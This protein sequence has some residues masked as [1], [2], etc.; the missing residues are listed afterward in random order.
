M[1]LILEAYIS[2]LS[3]TIG[4]PLD[5]KSGAAAEAFRIADIARSRL[6]LEALAASGARAAAG[7]AEMADLIRREQDAQKQISALYGLLANVRAAPTDQQDP[8]AVHALRVRID[9]LRSAR[10]ALGKEIEKRFPAYARLVNPKPATVAQAQSFIRPGEALIATYVAEDRTYV[11]A[12]PRVGET[13]FASVPLGRERIAAAVRDLRRALDPS[14]RTL[15]EIPEFDV[16]LAHKLYQALLQPVRQG[17]RDANSLLVV[18]HGALGQ[19]PFSVLVTVP[20]TL[21]PERAPLFANYREVPWLVRSHAVTN[22][23]SVASRQRFAHCR[24]A[25][26]AGARSWASAILTSVNLRRRRRKRRSQRG[27]RRWRAGGCSTCGVCRCVSGRRRGL[28]R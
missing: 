11:W 23:P 17:W 20:A 19:L 22:L 14:A 13:A 12:V 16:A 26:R 5:E 21:G 7:N 10:G 8:K 15:G 2:L 6:V 9:R 4:T 28:R 27:W 1:A 18:A 24:R 3:D 25:I